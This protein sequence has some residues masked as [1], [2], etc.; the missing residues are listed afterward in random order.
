MPV[1]GSGKTWPTPLSG[2]HAGSIRCVAAQRIALPAMSAQRD[3]LG[4]ADR[5][6]RRPG[7]CPRC[8]ETQPAPP[9]K[10]VMSSR[11][12]TKRSRRVRAHTTP[13]GGGIVW[14]AGRDARQ[15]IY[16]WLTRMIRPRYQV[17]VKREIGSCRSYGGSEPGYL[18]PTEADGGQRD[19]GLRIDLCCPIELQ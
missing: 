3:R 2:A 15:Q 9:R 17:F 19:G 13:S 7:T 14:K 4:S 11:R 12:V 8:S 6:P 5:Q 16:P 18:G 1:A 10:G